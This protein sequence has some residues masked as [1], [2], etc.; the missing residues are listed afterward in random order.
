[1]PIKESLNPEILFNQFVL[2][3]GST[4]RYPSA[5]PKRE[6]QGW[7]LAHHK[8][9]PI[10][11]ILDQ[12]G[13]QIGWIVGH[14]ISVDGEFLPRSITLNLSPNDEILESQ[15]YKL[16]G[17]W[18]AILLTEEISRVYLDAGGSLAVVYSTQQPI[19]A[20]TPSLIDDKQHPY[21]H[22]LVN[23]L[24]L[25]NTNRW[26]P[27]GLTPKINLH[28]LLPN[29][30]LD[31]RN[32]EAKRHHYC[33]PYQEISSAQIQTN[34]NEIV[35]RISFVFEAIANKGKVL[36]PLTAGRDSR[37]LLA[38]TRSIQEHIASFT[39]ESGA[40][41]K[42]I[43]EKISAHIAKRF[44]LPH[45]LVPITISD[46]RLL[47]KWMYLTGGCAGG[48]IAKIYSSLKE[49]DKSC[50][51]TPGAMG[52]LGR[53]YYWQESDQTT[54]QLDAAE[55][56][57]LAQLPNHPILIKSMQCWLT[58]LNEFSK[59]Q[60]LDLFYLEQEGGCWAAPQQYGSDC[61]VSH[62]I[63]PFVDRI[64]IDNM[65][66]LPLD[67]KISN[68]FADDICKIAWPDLL[69]VPFN[70]LTFPMRIQRKLSKLF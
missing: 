8:S 47:E 26:Y 60:I 39:F 41:N 13:E 14:T 42:V 5:W 11:D 23:L 34:I 3:Q 35:D 4:N 50:T 48:D 30:K 7:V 53:A 12:T 46:E 49:F 68:R 69:S 1:M 25:P 52:E 56:L 33:N 27:A 40:K 55:L 9:T 37:M 64:T 67:Y 21:N 43:D 15:L 62:H 2:T 24:D 59:H 18:V 22:E 63:M 16:S 51:L 44:R 70:E 29:H 20:S 36:L 45:R 28:R 31:L 32:L 54:E 65:M 66:C 61:F 19:V 17:R 10:A 58:N 6:L 57:R 38:C